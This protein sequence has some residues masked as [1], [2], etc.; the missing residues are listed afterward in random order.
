MNAGTAVGPGY[1]LRGGRLSTEYDRERQVARHD[2]HSSDGS[3][4]VTHSIREDITTIQGGEGRYGVPCP[5]F[6]NLEEDGRTLIISAAQNSALQVSLAL[7]GPVFLG[8]EKLGTNDQ[9]LTSIAWDH[10]HNQVVVEHADGVAVCRYEESEHGLEQD[11]RYVSG[12][13]S[14]WGHQDSGDESGWSIHW[15]DSSNLPD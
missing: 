5:I 9:P 2:A 14:R 12:P 1:Q 6:A 10:R 7:A 8:T 13:E 4:R 3:L 11:R 15:R